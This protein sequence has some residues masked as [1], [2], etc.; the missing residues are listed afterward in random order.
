MSG[1]QLISICLVIGGGFIWWL[2]SGTPAAVP[3][4]SI[5]AVVDGATLVLPLGDVVDLGREKDRL[6]REIARADGELRKIATKLANPDFLARARPEVVE[7]QRERE[8]DAARDRARLQA[9]YERL[10]SG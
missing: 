5:Q 4:G 8:A 10:S 6:A 7:E 1:T 2:R 3:A 9:A